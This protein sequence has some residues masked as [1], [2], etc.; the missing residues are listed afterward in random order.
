MFLRDVVPYR[1]LPFLVLKT[2][3]AESFP[4]YDLM[5]DNIRTIVKDF[6][7]QRNDNVRGFSEEYAL[8]K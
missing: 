6:Q 3:N 7:V 2:S 4:S 8:G 5:M 1:E